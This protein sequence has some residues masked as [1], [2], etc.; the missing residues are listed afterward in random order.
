MQISIVY[1]SGFGH[2]ERLAR[3]VEAGATEAGA[4]VSLLVASELSQRDKGPWETLEN[5]DAIIFGSPTYMGAVSAPFAEFA[6]ASAAVYKRH[7]WK[8]K[9]AA[10]FTNSGKPAGDK[11]ATLSQMFVLASQH[12]MLWVPPALHPG[13]SK[14]GDSYDVGIN[15]TGHYTGVATHSYSDHSPDESPSGNELETGRLLGAR[16][17]TLAARWTQSASNP[18]E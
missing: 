2:T 9:L 10:G 18:A 12:G 5:A 7:G 14:A 4:K 11:F 8:D 6:A 13:F 15:R 3:A 1:H 16:V 17:A